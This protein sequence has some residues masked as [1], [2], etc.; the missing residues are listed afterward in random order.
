[1]RLILPNYLQVRAQGSLHGQRYTS[2]HVAAST[3]STAGVHSVP[4]SIQGGQGGIA[5]YIPRV[6]RVV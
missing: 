5:R 6:G 2:V 4:G 1:M 3:V